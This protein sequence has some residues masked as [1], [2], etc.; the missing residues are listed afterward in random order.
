MM[1][2]PRRTDSMRFLLV[3]G[4]LI[5]G[6]VPDALS[7]QR[8]EPD[9]DQ[10]CLIRFVDRYLSA[11]LAHDASRA[12]FAGSVRFTEN[13]VA[14]P[15]TEGLWFT[16]TGLGDYRL[17]IADSSGGQAGLVGE[18]LEH[19]SPVMLA[20]R[21]KIEGEMIFSVPQSLGVTYSC[22]WRSQ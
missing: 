8:N 9:C 21:L 13:T 18:V 3:W 12:P 10:A 22:G 2:G 16:S 1:T 7:A 19:G 11:M 6:L 20:L 4:A 5:S 17:Y 15:L 14:L